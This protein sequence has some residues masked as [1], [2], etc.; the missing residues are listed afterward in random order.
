MAMG[1]LAFEI[2]VCVRGGE[3]SERSEARRLNA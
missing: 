3:A 1:I 2:E